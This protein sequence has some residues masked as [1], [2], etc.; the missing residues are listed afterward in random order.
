MK[1]PEDF[2]LNQTVIYNS[3]EHDKPIKAV[4][5]EINID[6]VTLKINEIE[7]RYNVPFDRIFLKEEFATLCQGFKDKKIYEIRKEIGL[8]ETRKADLQ[9][10]LS[11]I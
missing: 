11:K 8:L 5:V 10:R 6:C 9:L 7:H 4:I 2:Y 1:K 3:I